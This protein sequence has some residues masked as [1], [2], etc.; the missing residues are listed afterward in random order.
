MMT[1][2]SGAI[3]D[4]WAAWE[5]GIDCHES[6]R[7]WTAGEL[8]SEAER[9]KSDL[10]AAGVKP[11]VLVALVLSNTAVF[12]V[13]LVASL[14]L[15]AHPVLLSAGTPAAALR[16]IVERCGIGWAIHDFLGPNSTLEPDAYRRVATFSSA[17]IDVAL[18]DTG[19]ADVL[20]DPMLGG[21]AVVLHPTSGTYG[22]ASFCVRNQDVAVAEA[23][24][25]LDRIVPYRD[26]RVRVTTPLS[27]AYAYGFGLVASLLSHS[28]LVLD[29]HFNPRRLLESERRRPSDIVALVPPAARLLAGLCTPDLDGGFAPLA[30]FAGAPCPVAVKAAFEEAFDTRLFAIYGSTETGGIATSYV[31]E[32]SEPLGVG[33]PLPGV[34]VSIGRTGEFASLG[35]GTGEVTVRSTSMMQGYWRADT[36]WVSPGAFATGDVGREVDGSLTLVGRAREI[37][38]VGGF[39]VDPAEVEVV[40]LEHPAVV[41][42]AVYPGERPEGGE[43]VQGAVQLRDPAPDMEA[44]RGHCLER[45]EET[46]D[47][48]QLLNIGMLKAANLGSG[49]SF[50]EIGPQEVQDFLNRVKAQEWPAQDPWLEKPGSGNAAE[51]VGDALSMVVAAGKDWKGELIW[52]DEA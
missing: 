47:D 51:R 41:D 2:D 8:R 45:L 15:G 30:F 17:G 29:S 42:V 40:L 6:R 20:A 25:F 43:F 27:H 26:V 1:N 14:S 10:A 37:I 18:L 44:L 19:D 32:G 23:R 38:N 36:R 31:D 21:N 11:G 52:P 46:K 48:E 13:A 33:R 22:H 4:A 49:S 28:T 16:R 5:G 9:L 39:K 24:N 35:A 12:P 34:D 50:S 3:L 7:S